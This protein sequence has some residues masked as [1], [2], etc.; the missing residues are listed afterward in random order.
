VAAEKGVKRLRADEVSQFQ[1]IYTGAISDILDELGESRFQLPPSLRPLRP[2]MRLQG[3]A[4]PVR[5]EPR[6]GLD[7][8]ASIRRILTMLGEAPDASIPVYETHD[9]GSAHMG[10][11]SAT[12][13][14]ARGC[15]GVVIDGGVRDVR[16]IL[17]TGLPVF[18]RYVT[19][20]DCVPRWNLLE[21]N[22]H[23]TVGGVV[24]QAGDVIVAD[25]DG[26]V[27]IRAAIADRVLDQCLALVHTENAVRAAVRSGVPP[28]QAY[29]RFGKF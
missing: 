9:D 7:Y 14:L 25:E 16:Y 5:G 10:E 20:L 15:R 4:Y 12:A 13:L 19:P 18:S 24:I 11:L 21:W 1:D 6:E 26:V 17:E 22:T 3:F 8:D 2:G 23:A 28:L 27:R 29:D